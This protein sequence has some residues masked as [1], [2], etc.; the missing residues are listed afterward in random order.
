[1]GGRRSVAENAP[2][3]G[4]VRTSHDYMGNFF[5]WDHFPSPVGPQKPVKTW[6]LN[7]VCARTSWHVRRPE[8]WERRCRWWSCS[9]GGGCSITA[10]AGANRMG[11][12]KSDSPNQF[13]M[14]KVVEK[15]Y[16]HTCRHC[17][18]SVVARGSLGRWDSHGAEEHQGARQYEVRF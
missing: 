14:N 6:R 5:W 3:I 10:S 12:L 7:F 15:Q 11:H 8:N 9:V 16:E 18:V 4:V 17:G 1:M 2:C 13:K